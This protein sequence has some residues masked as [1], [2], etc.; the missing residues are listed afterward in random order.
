MLKPSWLRFARYGW[1]VAAIAAFGA[2]DMCFGGGGPPPEPD[3]AGV[4]DAPSDA[5]PDG[6]MSLR[7]STPSEGKG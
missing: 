7:A 1:F 2:R 5:P 3:D 6:P 4:E